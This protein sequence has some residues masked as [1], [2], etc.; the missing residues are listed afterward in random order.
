MST[1]RDLASDLI[2][3][4]AA[5]VAATWVMGK[6]SSALYAREN[7]EAR[8]QED[9]ARGGT[10][11]YGVA[12]QKAAH[13][14]GKD[15]DEEQ[16]KTYGSAIHWGLGAAAGAVYGYLRPRFGW[17]SWGFGSLFG[18]TFFLTVDE[19]G[20]T[21]LGLTPPPQAFPWQTHGRLLRH[22]ASGGIHEP[23]RR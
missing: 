9:E 23:R 22:R 16:A 12:A 1:A 18:A 5:G 13:A 21:L 20:N 10:T 2:L 15:V 14:L 4:A 17:A 19:A 11:A 6:A 7:E 8:R 3:G